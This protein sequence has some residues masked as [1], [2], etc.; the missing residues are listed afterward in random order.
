[1]I[2][3]MNKCKAKAR[4]WLRKDNNAFYPH[5][6]ISLDDVLRYDFVSALCS[7]LFL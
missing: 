2:E 1:M 5:G 4:S 3:G 7:L 6:I